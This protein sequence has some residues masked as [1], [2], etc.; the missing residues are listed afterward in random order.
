MNN[1]AAVCANVVVARAGGLMA[2]KRS[3]KQEAGAPADDSDP[4]RG[5]ECTA[6]V[7]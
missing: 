4:R 2:E 6:I 1:T 7:T 3:A 5:A